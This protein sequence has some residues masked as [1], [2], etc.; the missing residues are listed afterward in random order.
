MQAGAQCDNLV[1]TNVTNGLVH[2]LFR[3][4]Y[5][6]K[7]QHDRHDPRKQ[8]SKV[9]MTHILC[10]LVA[11]MSMEDVTA[12]VVRAVFKKIPKEECPS[13]LWV[14]GIDFIKKLASVGGETVGR[15]SGGGKGV[16]GQ[17]E[18]VM[19]LMVAKMILLVEQI[20]CGSCCWSF[21]FCW[22]NWEDLF[23]QNVFVCCL[24]VGQ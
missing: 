15:A 21:S 14:T 5:V 3:R 12:N 7:N 8:L 10:Y 6:K 23:K 17:M 16:A 24:L 9:E 13:D 22:Q 11:R 19:L 20:A 2:D 1:S 4:V 18:R